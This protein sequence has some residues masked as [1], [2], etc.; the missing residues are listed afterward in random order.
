MHTNCHDLLEVTDVPYH[1]NM[2]INLCNFFYALFLCS[3]CATGLDLMCE[4][5]V[6]CKIAMCAVV[7]R[8]VSM[9]TGEWY[10]YT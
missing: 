3:A 1:W 2:A 8:S 9:T 6:M 5:A 10:V 4:I 7:Y